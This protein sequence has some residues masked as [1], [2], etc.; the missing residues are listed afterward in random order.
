[1]VHNP[2]TELTG[3]V[4]MKGNLHTH[5]TASDG[6]RPHQEVIDEYARRGHGFLS[7]SD[8]DVFTSA[9]VYRR[10]D[11]RGMILIPGNEISA[12]GPHLLH[13]GG[14]SLIAPEPDRQQ[15]IDRIR[16]DEGFAVFNHPNWQKGF[17]HCPQELLERC[18]GY[19]GIE[20]YNGVIS[21]LQGSP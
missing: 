9:E 19:L 5:T 11:D 2:Y 13:V 16:E 7:V 15:V 17:N 4:W 6:E 18:D 3:G 12:K 14:A 21:R 10:F 20:I 8:H 1:M